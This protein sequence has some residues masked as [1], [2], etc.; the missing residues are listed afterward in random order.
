MQPGKQPSGHMTITI[1]HAKEKFS[2]HV[3]RLVAWAFLGPQ[4]PE[5][6]VRHVDGDP[7]NNR[8]NN[9][10]YGTPWEN[11]QDT[12]GPASA[13]GTGIVVGSSLERRITA[14]LAGQADPA[15]VLYEIAELLTRSRRERLNH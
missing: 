10:A 8:L 15:Q 12:Y 4:P 6:F 13:T 3:H 1:T 5:A 14:A 7:S 9:L 11:I 2:T